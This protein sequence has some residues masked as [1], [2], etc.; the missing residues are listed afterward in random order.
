M[1][2]GWFDRTELKNLLHPRLHSTIPQ[3]VHWF[4]RQHFRQD[5]S[6]VKA[7]QYLDVKCFMGELV[8]TKIDRASMAN[9][10]EVRVPYLDHSLFEYIF[11]CRESHYLSPAQTKKVLYELIKDQLPSTILKR[12]KQGFVGPDH[13]YMNMEFYRKTLRNS[14]LVEEEI[15]KPDYLTALLKENY[16]WKLWKIVVLEKWFAYWMA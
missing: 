5:Y 16:N 14:R 15:I 6:P 13:Y 11:S 3:D 1:A 2:M 4:Y 12:K 8:L 9:S 10:L 7:I